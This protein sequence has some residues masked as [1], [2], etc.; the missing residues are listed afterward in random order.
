MSKRRAPK[1]ENEA[2]TT[3]SEQAAPAKVEPRWRKFARLGAYLAV[4][5]VGLS[6]LAA[7]S[8]YA[9]VED[10]AMT[11]GSELG[12]L[13]DSGTVRAVRINDQAINVVSTIDPRP[14]TEVL[15]QMELAC[16]QRSAGLGKVMA[17]LPEQVKAKLPDDV[18]RKG[19]GTMRKEGERS[20]FVACLM[21]D[22][23]PG[24][25]TEFYDRM[26]R[27]AETGDVSALGNV[28]YVHVRS[29]DEGKSH[30]VVAWT[31]GPLQVRAFLPEDGHDAPGSDVE[32]FPRPSDSQ[33]ILTAQMDGVPYGIRL[34][35]TKTEPDDVVKG[36]D[37]R[38]GADGWN[39]VRPDDQPRSRAFS[40]G[41]MDVM[42]FA[43]PHEGGT[44]IAVVD[45]SSRP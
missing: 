40:R 18:D 29:T 27:F 38:L 10:G 9:N 28:R 42:L 1:V 22:D 45:I 43:E 16:D 19:T 6:A 36:Y 34:Y 23:Q 13:G 30:V 20:G 7:R 11:L 26:T 17:E 41:A 25:L 24:T 44:M 39:L 12:K 32:G 35:Q 21:R 3:Q 15:D 5:G 31:D 37:E 2:A 8:V 14:F 4:V 33:R